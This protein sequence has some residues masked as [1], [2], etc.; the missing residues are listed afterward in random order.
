M[1]RT[2]QLSQAHLTQIAPGAHVHILRRAARLPSATQTC[3]AAPVPLASQSRGLDRA[4][5]RRPGYVAR[6]FVLGQ[7]IRLGGAANRTRHE[8]SSVACRGARARRVCTSAR[9]GLVAAHEQRLRGR[10]QRRDART[11][12]TGCARHAWIVVN[13]PGQRAPDIIR[14]SICASQYLNAFCFRLRTGL[15]GDSPT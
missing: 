11:A 8:L 5:Q 3:E 12:F 14:G 9:A 10:V 15:A 2:C 4:S 13:M 1:C 7:R 6:R